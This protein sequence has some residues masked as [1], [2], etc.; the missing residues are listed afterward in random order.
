MIFMVGCE[1]TKKT[2]SGI[3]P[4]Q[5]SWSITFEL[6][7]RKKKGRS[8]RAIGESKKKIGKA[9]GYSW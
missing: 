8:R 3:L 7:F 6:H 2:I 9:T 5:F 4:S 1:G